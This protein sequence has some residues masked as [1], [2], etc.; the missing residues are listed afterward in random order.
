MPKKK[1]YPFPPGGLPPY[2]QSFLVTLESGAVALARVMAEDRLGGQSLARAA[3]LAAFPGGAIW[4]D[5]PYPCGPEERAAGPGLDILKGGQ[6]E[7]P[8]FPRVVFVEGQIYSGPDSDLAPDGNFPPFYIFDSILQGHLA[9]P[10]PTR[11][12]AA[13]DLARAIGPEYPAGYWGAV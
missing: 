12:E 9:G 8:T 6:K 4:A 11:E 7:A 1:A 13:A 3:A 10:F 2:L 5:S